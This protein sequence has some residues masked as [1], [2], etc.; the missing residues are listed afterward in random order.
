MSTLHL[1]LYISGRTQS[2]E[3]AIATLK[4]ICEE[5]FAGGYELEVIDIL[6]HPE[7]A[8]EEQ[9]MVTPTLIK[10]LPPPM[11]AV[12]GDLTDKSKILLGL[13]LKPSDD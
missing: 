12:I 2:S 9:I 6:E 1:K 8:R 7:V 10:K 5:D 3:R 4:R 11:R 13:D